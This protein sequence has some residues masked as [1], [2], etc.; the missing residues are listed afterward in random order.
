MIPSHGPP[1][2]PDPVQVR[3]VLSEAFQSIL[4][5]PQ[6]P[7]RWGLPGPVIP[8]VLTEPGR[9]SNLG[10]K[11]PKIKKKSSGYWSLDCDGLQKHFTL[12]GA[13]NV[14]DFLVISQCWYYGDRKSMIL[15]MEHV[16]FPHTHLYMS[17]RSHLVQN[18]FDGVF[19]PRSPVPSRFLGSDLILQCRTCFE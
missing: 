6:N 9:S 7:G 16:A 10:S 8:G 5:A 13:P 3:Q 19:L 1:V 12:R 15:A 4:Q 11:E 18:A 17:R 2:F 14:V